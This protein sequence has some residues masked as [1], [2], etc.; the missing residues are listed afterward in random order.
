MD[1]EEDP[2]VNAHALDELKEQDAL[3]QPDA[4]DDVVQQAQA[5]D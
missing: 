1:T 3:A 4:V 2:V 5:L